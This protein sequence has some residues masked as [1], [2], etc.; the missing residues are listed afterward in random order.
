MSIFTKRPRP[1]KMLLSSLITIMH[2]SGWTMCTVC[3]VIEDPDHFLFV[4]KA[5][6]EEQGKMVENVEEVLDKE[7][8]NSIGDINL[9]VL[10]GNIENLS[11]QDQTEMLSAL[12]QYIK[13]TNRFSQN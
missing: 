9:R 3:L 13:S 8:L 10:C 4:C 12:M 6:D 7:G 1:A 5:Y 2:A 11:I